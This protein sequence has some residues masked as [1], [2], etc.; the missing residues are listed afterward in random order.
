MLYC[1]IEIFH[2]NA[3]FIRI[4]FYVSSTAQYIKITCNK[5]ILFY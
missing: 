2:R 3:Y 5:F 1:V 4:T